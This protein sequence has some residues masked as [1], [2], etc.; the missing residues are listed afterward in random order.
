MS[1]RNYQYGFHSP[2]LD[3]L[4]WP[5]PETTG[6]KTAHGFRPSLVDVRTKPISETNPIP[7]TLGF[8]LPCSDVLL[9]PVPETTGLKTAHGFRPSLTDVRTR[10]IPETTV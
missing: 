2:R 3:V 9:W 8:H 6:L 5:V 10:L 7:E 4:L 1:D